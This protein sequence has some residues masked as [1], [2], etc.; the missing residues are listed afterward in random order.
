MTKVHV[1]DAFEET[2]GVAKIVIPEQRELLS[3]PI[4]KL[5]R[6]NKP[7]WEYNSKALRVRQDLKNGELVLLVAYIIDDIQ[8]HET[9]RVEIPELRLSENKKWPV[10]NS[11]KPADL[12]YNPEV[13]ENIQHTTPGS[14]PNPAEGLG[15]EE[16]SSADPSPAQNDKGL[17]TETA[18]KPSEAS[19]GPLKFLAPLI[20]LALGIF[21]ENQF[22]ILPPKISD[23]E[24]ELSSAQD[25]LTTANAELTQAQSDLAE[26]QSARDE[27]EGQLTQSQEALTGQKVISNERAARAFGNLF[28]EILVP[29]DPSLFE[30]PDLAQKIATLKAIGSELDAIG[31]RLLDEGK[32]AEARDILRVAAMYGSDISMV[33]TTILALQ[34][35]EN[36]ELRHEAL[37]LYRLALLFREVRETIDGE[38]H[39]NIRQFFDN[40]TDQFRRNLREGLWGDL[41]ETDIPD[42]F[43]IEE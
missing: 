16:T 4:L 5:T 32:N 13:V 27:M 7:D 1:E 8:P 17:K 38:T 14:P 20:A 42:T 34:D 22:D 28:P 3:Q 33:R 43:G 37:Q 30:D 6:P 39:Q 29:D 25:A 2:G 10:I 36:P 35:E 26:A 11:I 21:L 15:R 24:T 9:V 31:K 19:S 12:V 41:S 18:P 40:T 23:L